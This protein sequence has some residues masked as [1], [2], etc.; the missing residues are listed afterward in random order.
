MNYILQK[1]FCLFMQ[2]FFGETQK[3]ENLALLKN[4]KLPGRPE[5]FVIRNFY[6]DI[7]NQRPEEHLVPTGNLD[8]SEKM[9]ITGHPSV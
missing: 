6:G 5:N 2:S 4:F 9:V 3:T 7:R 8:F 1:F